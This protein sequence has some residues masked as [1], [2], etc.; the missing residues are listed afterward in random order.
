MVF[1]HLA[2]KNS[3]WDGET[4]QLVYLIQQVLEWITLHAKN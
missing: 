1:A 4:T 2:L 3:V